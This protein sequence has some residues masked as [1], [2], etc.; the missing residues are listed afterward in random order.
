MGLSV[1]Q[2]V[3]THPVHGPSQPL[4]LSLFLHPPTQG[5]ELQNLNSELLSLETQG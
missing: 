2:A 5:L 4:L 1:N 3:P